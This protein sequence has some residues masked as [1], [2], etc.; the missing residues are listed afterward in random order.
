MN[1]S[2]SAQPQGASPA[3]TT[4]Y[5]P[6]VPPQG[7]APTAQSAW[8][9]YAPTGNTTP[10]STQ[11]LNATGTSA[12]AMNT[13]EMHKPGKTKKQLIA[14]TCALS[15][16][17]GTLG[18]VIGGSLSNAA[19]TSSQAGGGQPSAMQQPG[20]QD[21]GNGTSGGSNAIGPTGNAQGSQGGSA[22]GTAPNVPNDNG[23]S[24]GESASGGNASN[25]D[26]TQKR[27]LVCL[28][29]RQLKRLGE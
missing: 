13:S 20:T 2:D 28:D 15:L 16:V 12:A 22:N 7:Q 19:G 14:L 11:G 21:G 1:K 9:A 18:G 29:K 23:G 4:G 10:E 6:P 3:E 17:C 27:Q 25:N 5:I 26:S 8:S 24:S